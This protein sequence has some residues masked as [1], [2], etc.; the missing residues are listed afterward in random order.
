MHILQKQLHA[1]QG[2]CYSNTVT[3]Q[4][5]NSLDLPPPPEKPQPGECCERGCEKCVFD[6]Y[7]EAYKRWQDRIA[8]ILRDNGIE[9]HASEQ[10]E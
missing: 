5:T 4:T 6:Y 1:R 2:Y 7:D 10:E 8:E 9:F 3:D